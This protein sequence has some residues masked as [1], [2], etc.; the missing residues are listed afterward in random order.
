[1]KRFS[2]LS[3]L[4]R[5][6][7]STS[8]S[9]SAILISCI[10]LTL[11]ACGGSAGSKEAPT[12]THAVS[13]VYRIGESDVIDVN[14]W[15]NP[16]ISVSA[17]VRPDGMI[18]MPLIGDVKASEKTTEKLAADI[19]AALSDYVRTPQVTVIV[20]NPASSDFRNRVRVTGAVNNPT[21][22]P[23]RDGMTVLDVVLSAGGLSEF[24]APN[25]ALLYRKNEQGV[26][27]AYSILLKD[28]FD[29]GKLK[30]NYPLQPS[31]II[32]V[33]ERNF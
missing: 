2:R 18:T 9:L 17:T 16:E 8:A 29:R 10:L 14:V 4:M 6:A 23:Y 28:I 22:I 5:A 19:V 26:V 27:T 7:K 1:M 25:K 12:L 3:L 31:D 13:N 24:A 32:T 15:K 30:T 20:V 33:P 11:T 21:S